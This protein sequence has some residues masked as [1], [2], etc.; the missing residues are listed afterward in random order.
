M[1][2][3]MERWDLGYLYPGFE[4]KSFVQDLKS[5]QQDAESLRA[6]LKE[7]ETDLVDLLT[8]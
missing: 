2:N 6:L 1:E 7:E 4:D 3:G 5:L 8:N